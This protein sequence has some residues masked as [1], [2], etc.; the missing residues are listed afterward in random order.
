MYAAVKKATS[1]IIKITDI[2]NKLAD[3]ELDVNIDVHSND[4]IGILAESI[5]SLTIRL[6]SYISYI[7]E[8][9]EM[10]DEMADGKL[11]MEFKND[12]EG[13]FAKLKEA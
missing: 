11:H 6:K 9:V 12:Y 3:G 4:E 2:T 1:P 5:K 13:E 7:D 10:L 8:S